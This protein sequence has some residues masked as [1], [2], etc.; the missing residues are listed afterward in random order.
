MSE[1]E[2]RPLVSTHYKVF[3]VIVV[4]SIITAFVIM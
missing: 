1:Q 3:A 4:A 2:K